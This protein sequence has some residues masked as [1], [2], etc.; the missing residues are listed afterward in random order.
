MTVVTFG[1][2][3]TC[4]NF[5]R[6]LVQPQHSSP[7]GSPPLFQAAARDWERWELLQL[8]VPERNNATKVMQ[9]GK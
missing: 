7:F 6:L 3:M 5:D 4:C 2:P 9:I 8:S 1:D